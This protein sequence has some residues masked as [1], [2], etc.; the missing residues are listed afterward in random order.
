MQD[1]TTDR[2]VRE[3][4]G[5]LTETEKI[6]IP[7]TETIDLVNGDEKIT[8]TMTEIVIATDST[9]MSAAEADARAAVAQAQL[10][11]AIGFGSEIR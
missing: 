9:T 11:T 1:E 2:L 8:G 7:E 3:M 5:P 4:I 6:A 10:A